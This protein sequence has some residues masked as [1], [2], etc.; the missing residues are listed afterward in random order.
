MA[1]RFLRVVRFAVIESAVLL[2]LWMLFVS[3]VKV[4]EAIVGVAAAILGAAAAGMVK[5]KGFG[6][7]RPRAKWLLLFAF[8]P[9]YVLTGSASILWALAKRLLGKRSDAQFKVV[10]F[11][12]GKDPR[13]AA[14]RAL[15]ITLTTISPNSIVVGIDKKKN[16]MLVHQ[17][18]PTP[19]NRVT[20][21][22]GGRE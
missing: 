7:F 18:T 21:A 14:R 16:F 2:G 20:K 9:W 4:S 13:S 1:T 22:L 15:A 17:I 6:R 12:G 5:E 10:P 8:E 11:R 3:Q 19:T